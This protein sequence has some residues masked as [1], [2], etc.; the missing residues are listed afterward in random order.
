MDVMIDEEDPVPKITKRHLEEAMKFEHA[1]M[2]QITTSGSRR[3]S[4]PDNAAVPRLFGP[5]FRFPDQAGGGQGGS[6][7]P[8]GGNANLAN[9]DDDDLY[10]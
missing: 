3:C 7:A 2:C 6:S 5:H 1:G 8:G 9:D 4:Q 10:S